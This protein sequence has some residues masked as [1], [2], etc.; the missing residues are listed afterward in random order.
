MDDFDVKNS[1]LTL[2][3][4]YIPEFS[5]ICTYLASDKLHGRVN[6]YGIASVNTIF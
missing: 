5:L 3:K 6:L 1:H 4:S 2:E